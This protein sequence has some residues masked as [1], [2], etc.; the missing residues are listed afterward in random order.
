MQKYLN[1]ELDFERFHEFFILSDE[2]IYLLSQN[3]NYFNH[4]LVG[5]N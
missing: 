3:T 4:F 2:F 5:N 1:G